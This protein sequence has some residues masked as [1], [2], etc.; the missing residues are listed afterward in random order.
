MLCMMWTLMLGVFDVMFDPKT[1]LGTIKGRFDPFVLTSTINNKLRK[2]AAELISYNKHPPLLEEV[3]T[4]APDQQNA[5][6]PDP[7]KDKGK[8]KVGQNKKNPDSSCRGDSNE[9][10]DPYKYKGKTKVG[11]QK[12]NQES[13]CRD[14]TFILRKDTKKDHKPEAYEPPKGVDEA[15]CRDRYCRIH[16]RS[17]SIQDRVTKEAR[18]KAYS[19]FWQLPNL[20][21]GQYGREASYPPYH[22]TMFP[23][24]YGFYPPTRPMN[25][26]TSYL[27]NEN[28]RN[29]NTM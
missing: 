19:T 20:Y 7:Y 16:K 28:L 17:G 12:K 25:D 13:S 18:E 15:I 4:T 22:P 29:C 5:A 1:K 10:S 23:P 2:K 27:N 6:A 14:E 9:A 21:Q 24:E 3:H 11:Q 8:T 26:Y